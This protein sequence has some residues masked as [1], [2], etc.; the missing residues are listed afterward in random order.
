MEFISKSVHNL[1]D[2]A[3]DGVCILEE[4]RD[5][6]TKVKAELNRLRMSLLASEATPEDP[7]KPKWTSPCSI[8][9]RHQEA[10]LFKRCISSYSE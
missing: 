6:V 8:V 3:E 4:Y 2:S 1:D 9:T 7:V 10:S 5:Q